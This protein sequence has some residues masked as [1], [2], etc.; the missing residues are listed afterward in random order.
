[1]LVWGYLLFKSGFGA[2]L[3]GQLSSDEAEMRNAAPEAERGV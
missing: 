1:V 2:A 3:M